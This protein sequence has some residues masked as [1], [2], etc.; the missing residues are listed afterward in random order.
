MSRFPPIYVLRHGQTRWNAEGRLQGHANSPLT[1]AGR[2]QA[3]RQAALLAE[4]DLAEYEIRVSP[5]G[6]AF[7]TAAIALGARASRLVTDD[8]LMEIDIGVWTGR[9]RV[10]LD[11][12]T[13]E[14]GPHVPDGDLAFYEA[15]PDGEGFAAL[16]SRC[17]T[18]LISLHRPTIC[19][20]HGITSRMLRATAMGL[21]GA[22]LGD[23]PGGQGVIHVVADRAHRTLA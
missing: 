16:R 2:A 21:P 18:F 12:G 19:V 20:T 11:I 13:F 5:Q 15:A 8:R 22:A 23:L 9:R 1:E 4:F 10:D 3:L 17:E 14:Q 7:E 6:R